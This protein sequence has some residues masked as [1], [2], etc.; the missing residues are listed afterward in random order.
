MFAEKDI[1]NATLRYNFIYHTAIAEICIGEVFHQF[2]ISGK[3]PFS[4]VPRRTAGRTPGWRCPP[5]KHLSVLGWRQGLRAAWQTD[6]SGPHCDPSRQQAE[7]WECL[8]G[9]GWTVRCGPK[10]ICESK[11]I[12]CLLTEFDAKKIMYKQCHHK[13]YHSIERVCYSKKSILTHKYRK[14][15][16]I[17]SGKFS[18][19]SFTRGKGRVWGLSCGRGWD[20]GVF[21]LWFF[22]NCH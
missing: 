12:C 2:N 7:H 20:G 18:F 16:C 8:H 22:Q 15:L 17:Q 11:S 19:N 21:F 13:R 10:R 4:E 6:F 1:T 3:G 14:C 5:D 9:H